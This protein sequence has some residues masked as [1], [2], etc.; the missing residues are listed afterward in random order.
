MSG[1]GF[2]LLM[3]Y[4]WQLRIDTA[5]ELEAWKKSHGATTN[6][7]T[8]EAMAKAYNGA[9]WLALNNIK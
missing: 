6:A 7:Q 2:E 3:F 1:E 9:E 4:C 8:L 5:G